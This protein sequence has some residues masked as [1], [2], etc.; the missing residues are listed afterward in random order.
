MNNAH[1]SSLSAIA[2]SAVGALPSF[3]T[4]S[5]DVERTGAFQ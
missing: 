4:T 2:G 3:A 1:L 5:A